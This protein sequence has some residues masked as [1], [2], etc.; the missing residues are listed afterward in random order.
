MPDV[1]AYTQFPRDKVVQVIS[2][3]TKNVILR[4]DVSG[5]SVTLT[6]PLPSQ[7]VSGTIQVTAD[8]SD[9]QA[10]HS[11]D[12]LVDDLDIE[13]QAVSDPDDPNSWIQQRQVVFFWDST[14]VNNGPHFLTVQTDDLC[15][16]RASQIVNVVVRN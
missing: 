13:T 8:V 4:G 14:T 12:L 1:E 6:F 16:H 3:Q 7:S 5:P 11:V 15:G 9:N 2:G 10:I